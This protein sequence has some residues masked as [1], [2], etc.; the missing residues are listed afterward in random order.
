MPARSTR[1]E[2]VHLPFEG[3]ALLSVI[4]SKAVLLVNDDK[5]KDPTITLQIG[6]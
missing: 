3:D 6:A 5:I 1:E 4:L 2:K